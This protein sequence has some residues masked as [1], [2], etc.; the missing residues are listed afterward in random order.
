[1]VF[2]GIKDEIDRENLFAYV[3]QFDAEGN[4]K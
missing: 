1:M 2:P 4:T 3:E